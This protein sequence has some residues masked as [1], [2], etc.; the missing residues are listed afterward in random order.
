MVTSSSF[1][2][3]YA[4]SNV[5]IHLPPSPFYTNPKLGVRFYDRHPSIVVLRL[6]KGISS[7]LKSPI[8]ISEPGMMRDYL[9]SPMIFS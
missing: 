6:S 4:D 2:S 5:S 9:P 1:V 7:K 3:I 8:F